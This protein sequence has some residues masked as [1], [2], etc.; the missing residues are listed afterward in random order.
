M[1]RPEKQHA[2]I[3]KGRQIPNNDTKT[4]PPYPEIQ[5]TN[6]PPCA[7]QVWVQCVEYNYDPKVNGNPCPNPNGLFIKKSKDEYPPE[8]VAIIADGEKDG[9]III[10]YLLIISNGK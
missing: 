7:A 8:G 2:N 9:K 5:I 4:D 6:A 3:I 1:I 10:L